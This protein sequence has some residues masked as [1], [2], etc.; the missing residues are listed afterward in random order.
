MERDDKN[1]YLFKAEKRNICVMFSGGYD[2]TL[3]LIKALEMKRDNLVH[4]VYATYVDC[5]NIPNFEKQK[6]A[7]KNIFVQLNDQICDYQI[8][9]VKIDLTST[10]N[11]SRVQSGQMMMFL[12]TCLMGIPDDTEIWFGMIDHTTITNSVSLKAKE[13]AMNT[14]VNELSK[15][16]STYKD[17]VV[18][19]PI[20]EYGDSVET[21]KTFV[22]ENLL[23]YEYVFDLCF[24]CDNIY[25]SQECECLKHHELL[26]ALM[27][28]YRNNHIYYT[29]CIHAGTLIKTEYLEK[30]VYKM[31]KIRDYIQK[32]YTDYYSTLESLTSKEK[33][34]IKGTSTNK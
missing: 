32:H 31:N 3:L 33:L 18:K 13:Q 17:I 22:I 14:V 6:V 9:I 23:E 28:V 1:K 15:H 24:S 4:E 20:M 27:N 8:N 5:S 12:P 16:F 30:A 7:M 19:C 21:R 25:S 29:H 2:S 34:E 10:T 26:V 11:I